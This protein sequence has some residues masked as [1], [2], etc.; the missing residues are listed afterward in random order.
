[1]HV[2]KETHLRDGM[3]GFFTVSIVF[4]HSKEGKDALDLVFALRAFAMAVWLS[5]IHI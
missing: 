2:A 5:L 1:M 4:L 3:D